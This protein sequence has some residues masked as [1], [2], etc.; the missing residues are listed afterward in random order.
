[1]LLP[2]CP[3]LGALVADARGLHTLAFYCVLVAVPV[4]AVTSLAFF[5]ELVDG[6]A[7][8][9]SGALYVGLTALALLLVL[10]AA[11]ARAHAV[12][13]TV[14]ALGTSAAV[15]ALLLLGL[16]T[17]VWCSGRLTRAAIVSILRTFT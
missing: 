4:L 5:G 1:M 13:A 2:A 10:I 3:L 9:G 12:D 16:Q 7:D 8:E 15:G 14:P 17:C 11:A 6:S